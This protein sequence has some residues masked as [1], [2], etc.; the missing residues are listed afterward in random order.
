M[1]DRKFEQLVERL[2]K[3]D[4]SIGTEAFRDA[5]LQRCLAVLDADESGKRLDDADLELL[6]A[7]GDD[8]SYRAPLG[9]SE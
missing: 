8:T 7:A 3:L 5:L 9:T 6:S 2:M 4:F 1:G